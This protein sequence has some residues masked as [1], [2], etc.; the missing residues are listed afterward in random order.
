MSEEEMDPIAPPEAEDAG[1]EKMDVIGRDPAH[2]IRPT[3]RFS[4][5]D[6]P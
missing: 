6:W 4:R 5:E 2:G 1:G 3:H